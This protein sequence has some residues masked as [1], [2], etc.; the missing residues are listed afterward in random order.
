METTTI[1]ETVTLCLSLKISLG[2]MI[3]TGLWLMFTTKTDDA[4]ETWV[5]LFV[6]FLPVLVGGIIDGIINKFFPGYTEMIVTLTGIV[7]VNVFLVIVHW[8]SWRKTK[9][10][11]LF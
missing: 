3:L 7:I 2:V 5:S 6:N 10:E 1:T 4:I 9:N 11:F 8:G